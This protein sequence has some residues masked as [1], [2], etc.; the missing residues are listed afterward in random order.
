M[1]PDTYGVQYLST[2]LFDG[3]SGK[4]TGGL[5]HLHTTRTATPDHIQPSYEEDGRKEEQPLKKAE[6]QI[7]LP[8]FDLIQR[9]DAV[10][11]TRSCDTS[12]TQHA[13]SGDSQPIT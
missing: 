11:Y 2:P 5:C 6:V 3:M 8:S 10:G 12:G 4:G 9:S 13:H 1:R 7:L